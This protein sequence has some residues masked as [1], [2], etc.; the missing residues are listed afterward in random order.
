MSLK[1]H[2]AGFKCQWNI[3]LFESVINTKLVEVSHQ[4]L[5]LNSQGAIR[6][7]WNE[8]RMTL[9]SDWRGCSAKTVT[10]PVV[11][12]PSLAAWLPMVSQL[13]LFGFHCPSLFFKALLLESRKDGFKLVKVTELSCTST[14]LLISADL[15]HATCCR[16]SD[17]HCWQ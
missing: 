12:W 11:P 13:W 15:G 6:W 4:C 7:H 14:L 2:N 16:W 8:E 3:R 17:F 9:L 10:L 1:L 5:P